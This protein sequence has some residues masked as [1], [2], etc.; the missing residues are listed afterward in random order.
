MKSNRF[1]AILAL[2][3]VML[4]SDCKKEGSFVQFMLTSE[5]YHGDSKTII[6]NTYWVD[7]DMIK[8]NGIEYAV[9]VNESRNMIGESKCHLRGI[10]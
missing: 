4:V 7:G 9:H 3:I 8:L 2:A 6:T 5:N 10:L 1:F